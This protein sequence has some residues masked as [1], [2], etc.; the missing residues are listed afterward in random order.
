MTALSKTRGLGLTLIICPAF[1]IV[2]GRQL[3]LEEKVALATKLKR[4]SRNK[5]REHGELPTKWNLH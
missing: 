3:S 5:R 4:G 2:Q 1:D